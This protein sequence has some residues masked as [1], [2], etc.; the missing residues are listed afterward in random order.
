MIYIQTVI[1]LSTSEN[2][3]IVTANADQPLVLV[4]TTEANGGGGG[5]LTPIFGFQS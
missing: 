1:S 4:G 2:G 5:L 3:I